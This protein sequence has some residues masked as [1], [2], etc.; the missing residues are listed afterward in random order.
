MTLKYYCHFVHFYVTI[1]IQ[2]FYKF[3]TLLCLGHV[4]ILN[5][6]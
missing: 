1:S 3:Q 2:F 4:P 5:T 6:N